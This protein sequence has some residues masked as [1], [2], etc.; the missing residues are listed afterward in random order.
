MK[1]A[2]TALAPVQLLAAETPAASGSVVAD[3][4]DQFVKLLNT[5]NGLPGYA[6][7]A[8]TCIVAGYFLR[9]NKR[10]PNDA[11]PMSCVLLGMVL[12]PLISDPIAAGASLRVWIV[13]NVAIG[14]IVG[15]A[16]WII[17]RTIIKRFEHRIPV[18]GSMLVDSAKPEENR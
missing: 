12:N 3:A 18:L 11:I 4:L 16:A 7:V 5:I 8:L 2:M 10:F 13:R 15:A 17:H 9:L 1:T 6:L 14:A